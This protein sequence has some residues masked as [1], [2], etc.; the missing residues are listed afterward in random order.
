MRIRTSDGIRAGRSC[1]T[2]SNSAAPRRRRRLAGK[3]WCPR[4][5]ELDTFKDAYRRKKFTPAAF[6]RGEVVAGF[7]GVDGGSTSTKAALLDENGDILCKSYQLS[8]GNPIQDTMQM[9]EHLREQVEDQGAKLEVLGVGTTGLCEGHSERCSAWGCGAGGD[10]SAHGIG[11][12]LLRRPACHRR[13]RRSGYQADCPEEWPRQG[14]QA[15]H[16]MLGRQ[17][18]LPAIH[19]GDVRRPGG[20]VR[21]PGVFR[22]SDARLRLWLRGI[23]AVRHRELPAAGLAR[24]G[25]PCGTCGR[26]AEERFPLCCSDSESR[27]SRIA[28][29]APGRDAE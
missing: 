15:E 23:H 5:S 9:F 12:A 28:I 25:D 3:A 19:G 4:N 1:N 17:R 26:A 27:E 8:N 10:R 13:C 20:A 21:R 16:A 18:I 22:H 29:R 11:D 6:R 14:F 2:T 7:I 24:R